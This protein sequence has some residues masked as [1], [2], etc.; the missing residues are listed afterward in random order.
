MKQD[1][2]DSVVVEPC[3]FEAQAARRGLQEQV[4]HRLRNKVEANNECDPA[5]Q[6][7]APLA[8]V[9]GRQVMAGFGILGQVAAET[10]NE[11]PPPGAT[12][13]ALIAFSDSTSRIRLRGDFSVAGIAGGE[14]RQLLRGLAT[15]RRATIDPTMIPRHG[16]IIHSTRTDAE[17][18]IGNCSNAL[19]AST[20]RIRAIAASPTRRGARHHGRHAA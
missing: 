3:W 17:S 13:L 14:L 2:D 18:G 7:S 8:H 16:A 19:A 12:T 6:P 10:L 20:S 1:T 15:V 11:T 9:G 5:G 4:S